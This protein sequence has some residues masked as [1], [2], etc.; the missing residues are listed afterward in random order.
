MEF[1]TLDMAATFECGPS[2]ITWD[3]QVQQ[4]ME[5]LTSLLDFGKVSSILS[6][7]TYCNFQYQAMIS[8]A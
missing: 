8:T 1:L 3:I 6:A 2:I 5:P 7:G 4:T